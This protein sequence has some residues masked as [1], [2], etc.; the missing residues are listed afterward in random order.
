MFTHAGAGAAGEAAGDDDAAAGDAGDEAGEAEEVVLGLTAGDDAEDAEGDCAG[1]LGGADDSVLT[2]TI[3]ECAPLI[4]GAFMGAREVRDETVATGTEGR[5]EERCGVAMRR[6]ARG[7]HAT[8]RPMARTR[9]MMHTHCEADRTGAC[10]CVCVFCD[11]SCPAAR[12]RHRRRLGRTQES[13]RIAALAEAH[14]T[15]TFL[16]VANQDHFANTEP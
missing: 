8:V 3:F 15:N 6:G 12:A 13:V 10:G 1:G 16:N 2:A 7:A 11:R 14:T 9:I 4:L 5:R